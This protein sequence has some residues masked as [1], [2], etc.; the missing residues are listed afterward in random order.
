VNATKAFG[1]APEIDRTSQSGQAFTWYNVSDREI[2]DI[3]GLSTAERD[4]IKRRFEK[5][6]GAE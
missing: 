3:D 5:A 1:W 6:R 2:D 4:R